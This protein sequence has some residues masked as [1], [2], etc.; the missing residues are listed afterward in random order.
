[1]RTLIWVAVFLVAPCAAGCRPGPAGV[2]GRPDVVAERDAREVLEQDQQVTV[3]VPS[4]R[5]E[6]VENPL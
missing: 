5:P 4:P 2:K 6:Q 1:M 3:A